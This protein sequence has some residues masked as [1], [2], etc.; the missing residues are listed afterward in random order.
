MKAALISI[1]LFLGL[2]GLIFHL[3]PGQELKKYDAVNRQIQTAR[4]KVSLENYS[5]ALASFDKA[6][7]E[8]PEDRFDLNRQLRLEKAKTQM[9]DRQ[10]PEARLALESLM[11]EL[12]QEKLGD[13]SLGLQTREALANSQYY[14]TWLMRLEGVPRE[15]WEP[16]IEASR[17]NYRWLAEAA[18]SMGDAEEI[19][20]RR[21]DVEAAVRLARLDLSELQALPLPCQCQGCK[22]C[23]CRGKGKKPG[24][25]PGKRKSQGKKPATGAGD[26]KPDESMGS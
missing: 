23:N 10:L 24:K 3:G 18:D 19:K 13:S 16:E 25:K 22:S 5:E 9:L 4:Q 17:Q 26:Q 15:E 8:L 11:D 21:E 14:V 1:W 2:S 12:M 20:R 7:A 6:L